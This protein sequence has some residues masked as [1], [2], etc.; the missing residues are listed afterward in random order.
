MDWGNSIV[1]TPHATHQNKFYPV[2]HFSTIYSDDKVRFLDR[3]LLASFVGSYAT[4]IVRKSIAN[5][6][7][8]RKDCFTYDTGSW[9]YD[10]SSEDKIQFQLMYKHTLKNS[11]F[12]LCPLGTGPSTIRIWEALSSGSIPIIISDNLKLP[13][14]I[15][16][17]LPTVPLSLIDLLPTLLEHLSDPEY[18]AKF[19]LLQQKVYGLHTRLTNNTSLHQPVLNYILNA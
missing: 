17:S 11:K 5:I 15:A 16:A 14:P 9:H 10:K 13:S 18:L 1:F 4:H 3:P 19:E 6:L 12:V 7:S 2:A 8:I